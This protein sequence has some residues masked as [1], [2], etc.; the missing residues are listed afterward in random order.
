MRRRLLAAGAALALVAALV[1]V[2]YA[3]FFDA[4]DQPVTA[5]AASPQRFV[6]LHSSATEPV[7]A[8]RGLFAR[9]RSGAAIDLRAY[10][11]SGGDA[12]PLALDLGSSRWWNA[13]QRSMDAVFTL[14]ATNQLPAGGPVAI[15]LESSKGF[16]AELRSPV[17][18][19]RITQLTEPRGGLSEDHRGRVDLDVTDLAP[20]AHQETLTVRLTFAD[21]STMHYV[22]PVTWV[23]G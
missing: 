15:G 1:P 19:R 2:S 21:T 16:T 22:V 9:K 20:G 7:A 3:F 17:A 11:A 13:A 5:T 18:G 8:V 10:I 4:T 6:L 14:Q 23:V 12:Q